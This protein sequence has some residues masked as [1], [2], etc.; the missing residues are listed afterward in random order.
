MV[1][2]PLKVNSMEN[3]RSEKLV[4]LVTV[5][6][7]K[8][9]DLDFKPNFLNEVDSD[10]RYRALRTINDK[11]KVDIEWNWSKT[12]YSKIKGEPVVIEFSQDDK[13]SL[14]DACK[15]I[16]DLLYPGLRP[17]NGDGML[18]IINDQD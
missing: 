10:P 16:G 9:I 8:L 6:Q 18:I 5:L 17:I 2:K 14:I 15:V 4:E 13:I 3:Q 7:A 11:L 1:I 12:D